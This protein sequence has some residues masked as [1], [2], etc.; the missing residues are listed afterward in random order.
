MPDVNLAP[1]CGIYCGACEYLDVQCRGC[2]YQRGRPFW[3][4]HMDIEVCP[5]YQCCLDRE[6]VEH[7]GLCP[8]FPCPLFHQFRD[9]SLSEEEA[10]R[11]VL[12]RQDTLLRRIEIG[13]DAWLVEQERR[14]K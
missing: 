1:P 7:C 10:E 3:T 4:S 12:E 9:P 11:A 8:E 5:L 6:R 2:G 14:R 13:T